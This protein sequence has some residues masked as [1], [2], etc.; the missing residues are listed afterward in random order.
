MKNLKVRAIVSIAMLGSISAILMLFNFPIPLFP[1]FLL[2][3]FSD[4]PALIAALVFGPLAGVLVEFIK[5]AL[6]YL[7]VGSATGVPV[8]Q[9]SN[10]LAGIFFIIPTYYLYKKLTTRKGMSLAL[11]VGSVTMGLIMSILNYYV[12]LPAYTMFLN[13]PAMSASATRQLIVTAILPFNIIKGIVMSAVFF[14]LF[15]RMHRWIIKNSTVIGI[16]ETGRTV[17]I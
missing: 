10:F 9:M 4:I 1:N 3:D 16:S 8:G 14:V 11:V 2:I 12:I 6:N 15:T 13:S 5:N 7:T 17:H